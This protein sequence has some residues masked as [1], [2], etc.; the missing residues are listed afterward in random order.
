MIVQPKGRS[1]LVM[2][3]IVKVKLKFV[4]SMIGPSFKPHKCLVHG[5]IRSTAMLA[6]KRLAGVTP[7]VNFREHVTHM[8][9]PSMNKAAHSGFEAL[10]RHHQKS[11][12]GVSV[13]PQKDLCRPNFFFKKVRIFWIS[14]K[15]FHQGQNWFYLFYSIHVLFCDYER[16][17]MYGS[18]QGTHEAS[19]VRDFNE[20][21]KT[22]FFV[23]IRYKVLRLIRYKCCL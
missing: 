11:K 14:S 8:P 20:S 18:T 2:T 19:K 4:C 12:T 16:F 9:L 7:E 1:L 5:T 6:A 22:L 3:A 15:M 10:R 23:D 17:H 13:T 21:L